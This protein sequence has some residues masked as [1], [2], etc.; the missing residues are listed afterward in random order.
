MISNVKEIGRSK[1]AA[2][3]NSSSRR[4]RDS[5]S[6]QGIIDEYEELLFVASGEA[7]PSIEPLPNS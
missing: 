4:A 6:K 7:T 2:Q 1:K 3:Y 5:Q